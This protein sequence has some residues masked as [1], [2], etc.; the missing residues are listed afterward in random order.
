MT[1]NLKIMIQLRGKRVGIV[2]LGRI[3]REVAKRLEVFGCKISYNSRKKKD[4]FSY[5]FYA[6]LRDLAADSDALVVCCGLTDQTRH[7]IDKT[8]LSAL[9]KE[10]VIVNVGRGAI[11]NEM[12]MVEC[13]VKEE[14][15]GAGLDVFEY[16]PNVPQEL[17]GLE[18]VV[19]SP[20]CAVYTAE[21]FECLCQL[22]IGNLEA[23]FSDKPLLSQFV[24][25]E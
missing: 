14:I 16:E 23:F 9:G 20:H 5:P 21:T 1:L 17:S 13:L 12:E 15:G 2:G 25:D 10:G 24:G 8:V 3:G 6:N 18:N 19:L 22:M 7:M 4:F 11:V